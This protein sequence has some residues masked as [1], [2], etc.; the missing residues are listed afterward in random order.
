MA[1]HRFLNEV[2]R[3]T[4]FRRLKADPVCRAISICQPDMLIISKGSFFHP[5]AGSTIGSLQYGYFP[6]DPDYGCRL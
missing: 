1:K 2:Q 5:G 4:D 3:R 6:T